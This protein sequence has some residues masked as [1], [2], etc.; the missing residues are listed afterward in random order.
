[1]R[2]DFARNL[3]LAK[4]SENKVE[5]LKRMRINTQLP[6]SITS[7]AESSFKKYVKTQFT[8]QKQCQST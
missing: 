8:F 6:H 4:L 5:W 2:L 7:T 3:V 1:M